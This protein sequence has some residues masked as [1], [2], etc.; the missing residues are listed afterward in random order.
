M[1]SI[2]LMIKKKTNN[3]TSLTRRTTML[4]SI[5]KL[6]TTIFLDLR[7]RNQIIC[8]QERPETV[9]DSCSGGT[10]TSPFLLIVLQ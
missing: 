7:T 5:I 8:D 2:I 1:K 9:E 3:R 4:W 6:V 10:N